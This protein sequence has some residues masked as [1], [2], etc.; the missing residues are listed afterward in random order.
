MLDPGAG[1][2]PAQVS[3]TVFEETAAGLVLWEQARPD[4]DGWQD[5]VEALGVSAGASRSAMT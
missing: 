3:R 5:V 1:P 4:V 2:T